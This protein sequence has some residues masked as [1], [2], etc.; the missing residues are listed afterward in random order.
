[1]S[2][3]TLGTKSSTVQS[4]TTSTPLTIGQYV[5]GGL[6]VVATALMVI[7][8]V[9]AVLFWSR[10]FP[11]FMV[12]ST[13][14]VNSGQSQSGIAWPGFIAGIQPRDQII[15]VNGNALFTTTDYSDYR[16]AMNRYNRLLGELPLTAGTYAPVTLEVLRLAGTEND[17]CTPSENGYVVCSK[18]LTP[19][20]FPD[21]DFLAYFLLPFAGAVLVIVMGWL[22]M[23]N[24]SQQREGLLA[25]TIAFTSAIFGGGLFDVGTQA[26]GGVAWMLSTGL[27]GGALVTLSLTFP[28]RLRIARR[29][30]AL[31]YAPLIIGGLIGIALAF[32][33]LMPTDAITAQMMTQI[34]SAT[35]AIGLIGLLIF[36][37]VQRERATSP[38]TRDQSNTIFIG[39]ALMMVA[40]VLWLLSRITFM[41]TQ[42]TLPINLEFVTTVFIFPVAAIAYAVLHYPTGDTDRRISQSITYLIMLGALIVAVFLLALGGAVLAIELLNVNNALLIAVILFTMVIVFTPLRLRLQERI[43]AIYFRQRRNLQ[44]KTEEFSNRLTNLDSYAEITKLFYSVLK[45][46]VSPSSVL[47]YLRDSNGEYSSYKVN[48][49]DTEIRFSPDSPMVELLKQTTRAISLQPGQQW[50]H[51]LW[52]DQARLR[53]LRTAIIAPIKGQSELSGFV[54]LA[55]PSVNEIYTHE[56]VQFVE[57]LVNQLTIATQRS[58]VIESLQRRVD[59]LDVLS[60]VGQAVNFTIEFDELLELI[61]TQASRLIEVPNFYIALYDQRINR[62]YFA[63]FLEDDDRINEKEGM[64]WELGIDLF[65]EVVKKN[66][67]LNVENYKQELDKRGAKSILVTEKLR[68]W[69]G[70]PLTAGR[71]ILGVIAVGKSKD[72][73]PYNA[74]AFKI[75]N[76]I[77]SLAATSLDKANLFTQTKLRERQLTVLND[78]SRQLVATES[79]VEK[80]LVI[81]MNSSVEILNAEAGSLLLNTED[82]SGD[83]EFRVVSGGGGEGLIGTRVAAGQGVVGQ[84]VATGEPIIVNDAAND[85]R[86]NFELVENFISRSLLAVPL[87]AKDEVI[88]VLEVLN[89]NDGTPF[90]DDDAALLTTFAGQAAI[91]IENARLF[92]Q[93]DKQL[94]QRV[95]ELEILE[96]IDAELNRT[97]DLHEVAGITVKSAMK[98]L[99]AN[100]GALGIVHQ[101]PP[102]LEVVA[103]EGYAQNEY[104][105]GANDMIWP[106]NKGII[107]RVMR[108]RQ[109]DIVMD[110]GNDPDYDKGLANSNSQI[111]L[112]MMSGDEVNAILILEKNTLPRFSLPDW[113]FAQRIAEHAS[114]AIANAQFYNALMQANKSK[115]D[116]MGFAAH[117]LKNPLTPLI[118]WADLMRRGGIGELSEQQSQI[119]NIIY[120]NAKRMDTIIGDLRDAARIDANEFKVITEAMNIYS[121][122]VETLRPFVQQLAD[123]NQELVNKVPEDLPLIMGDETRIIQV[124]T[125][126]VSNA[127]K[128]SHPDTTITIDAWIDDN[129]H[130]QD[131]KL[132]GKMLVVAVTDQGLGMSEA[133]QTKLFK[134]RY[135]RSTNKEALEQSG[136]GL[137]MML[138]YQI[139][140]GHEGEIWIESELGKGST[141]F[142][143]FPVFDEE[144]LRFKDDKQA[145]AD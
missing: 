127:N 28:R 124:L 49:T 134:E 97:L 69:M 35:V 3:T 41:T 17:D 83:L 40:I 36:M 59:E 96:R 30:K 80:L 137:G 61:Y 50:P 42:T 12:S 31:E 108:S 5:V 32:F 112:P 74:E 34:G 24:G 113:A 76:D 22:V 9:T 82:D 56:E 143:S 43:D 141:F 63:F 129:Y 79:D 13:M 102:Y 2:A 119:A 20:A 131:G 25:A 44:E 128:Y 60:Q 1:M 51:E 138:T 93:T 92:Q 115:S 133:D 91:A 23:R 85:Q 65:S 33:H 70:V 114:I 121:A 118:G 62:M 21:I 26:I 135:F 110:V 73:S 87:I 104:P 64:R 120:S 54:L 15:S 123:K 67:S 53:L 37:I 140:R 57:N 48:G 4:Q 142:I 101:D 122:V 105:E 90:A 66:T 95:A 6:G 86:H 107:K 45:D 89:K 18:T 71:R 117:E 55:P 68:A 38:A 139:M 58:Q 39:S 132:R 116:F 29:I 99:G 46:T 10:P 7:Y 81:I 47:I 106:L 94:S 111:T 136:T 103:I 98:I 88:G 72:T 145:A 84:V 144:S 11:G 27:L 52:V 130:D 126:L 16:P 100:A 78:I 109:S 75:F 125:N 8:L 14:V 77:G 19:I